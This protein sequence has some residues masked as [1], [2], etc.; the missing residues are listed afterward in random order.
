VEPA[1]KGAARSITSVSGVFPPG[2]IELVVVVTMAI[3]PASH[4][5]T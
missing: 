2:L 3:E 1:L 5:L 4:M